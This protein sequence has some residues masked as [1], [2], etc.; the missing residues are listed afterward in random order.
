MTSERAGL[1]T[2]LK[3]P[4]RDEDACPRCGGSG[5]EPL[6]VPEI[7]EP[8]EMGVWGEWDDTVWLP[9]SRYPRRIDAIR[10]A[11]QQ[12]DVALPEVS[13]LSRWMRYEPHVERDSDG[14]VLWEEDRW[15]ECDKDLSGAFRVWRL[16][17]A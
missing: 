17:S 10:W 11:M 12:W 5:L 16:E 14:S 6:A 8:D 13:C 7:R 4:A 1:W 9:R 2:F 3:L 15:W